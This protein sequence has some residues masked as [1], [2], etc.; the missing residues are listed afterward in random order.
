MKRIHSQTSTH[1][2]KKSEKYQS[3][4]REDKVEDP[5]TTSIASAQALGES[6]RSEIEVVPSKPVIEPI[7]ESIGRVESSGQL[8]ESATSL[9]G[10]RMR[11]VRAPKG[12]QDLSVSLKSS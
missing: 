5:I 10:P 6:I 12:S 11:R 8:E 2:R 3:P 9:N 7:Q 1:R 4:A